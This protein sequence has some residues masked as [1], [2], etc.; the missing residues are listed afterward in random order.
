M[1]MTTPAGSIDDARQ[2]FADAG[3][4]FPPVPAALEAS[5]VKQGEAI[6]GTRPAEPALSWINKGKAREPG[7]GML[8][9]EQIEAIVEYE[10]GL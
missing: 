6:F 2:F 10:R 7:P 5:V 4:A 3:L 8:T 1:P 9:A